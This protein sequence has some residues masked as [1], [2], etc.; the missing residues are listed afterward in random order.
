LV[1]YLSNEKHVTDKTPPTFL[2]HGNADPLV[3]KENSEMF[4]KALQKAKVPSEIHIL[5]KASHGFGLAQKD[6]NLK[7]WPDK[8]VVWLKE[9]SLLEKPPKRE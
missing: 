7:D 6:P 2:L 1:E 8:L 9:R 5:D 3:P 4:Y